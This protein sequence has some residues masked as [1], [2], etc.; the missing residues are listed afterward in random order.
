VREDVDELLR[1]EGN[2]ALVNSDD[3]RLQY[4]LSLCQST[5]VQFFTCLLQHL[6][7]SS[8]SCHSLCVSEHGFSALFTC[9]S[10]A[11]AHLSV[12]CT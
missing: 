1:A 9:Y 6:D 4:L 3:D 8:T 2:A 12:H 11:F 5:K 7:L 10:M